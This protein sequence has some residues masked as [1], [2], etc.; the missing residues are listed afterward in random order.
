MNTLISTRYA[1]MAATLAVVWT[2][3]SWAQT[4]SAKTQQLAGAWSVVS[5]VQTNPD[6]SKVDVFGK[7]PLGGYFLTPDGHC[8]V[9]FMRDDL[10]KFKSGVRQ[11]G[12]AEEY[13]AVV[14]GSLAYAGTCLADGENLTM[15]VQASTFPAW[16]GQTQKR[17]YTLEGEQLRW[18]GITGLQGASIA[19]TV[20]RAK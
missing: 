1:L 6:G 15:V 12:T 4:G 8:S 16:I 2:L 10:P 20:K 17:K 5:V 13:T 9:L 19:V 7:N 18:V 3:P 11:K 14:Q